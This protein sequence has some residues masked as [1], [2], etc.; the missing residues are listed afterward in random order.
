MKKAA[1]AFG[2]ALGI[3]SAGAG[4]VLASDAMTAAPAPAAGPVDKNQLEGW[5][6]GI[7]YRNSQFRLLDPRGFQRRV[8]TKPG[9]IG[10]YRIGDHVRVQIDPDY[11][12]ARSIEKLY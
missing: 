7:D 4:T 3:L 2:I 9:I 6:N 8:V 10:D 11:K 5:I 1:F 12:R